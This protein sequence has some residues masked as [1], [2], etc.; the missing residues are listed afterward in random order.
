MSDKLHKRL[1]TLRDFL[2]LYVTCMT[3]KINPK[4]STHISS[5][6]HESIF[7]VKIIVTAV[8]HK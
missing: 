3:Y 8:F 6:F 5:K 1:A 7:S 2:F 4:C